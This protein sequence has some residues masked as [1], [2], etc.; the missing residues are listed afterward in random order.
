MLNIFRKL[1]KTKKVADEVEGN[2][3]PSTL[4]SVIELIWSLKNIDIGSYETSRPLFEDDIYNTFLEYLDAH[5]DG[6]KL[7]KGKTIEEEL[8]IT[9]FKRKEL[10]KKAAADGILMKGNNGYYIW[11]IQN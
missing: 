7:P 3:I 2:K 11:K 9:T 5:R 6:A 8:K 10:S 1:K 4:N